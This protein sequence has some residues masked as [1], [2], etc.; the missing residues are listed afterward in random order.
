M[1]LSEARKRANR[2]YDAKTYTIAACKIRKD[3]MQRFKAACVEEGTSPNAVIK[4]A[5]DEF[6]RNH[7]KKHSMNQSE[8]EEKSRA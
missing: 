5:I 2:K 6:M 4:A 7:A 1:P 8:S 3:E